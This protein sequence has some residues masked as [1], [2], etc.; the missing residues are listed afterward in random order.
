MPWTRLVL[1]SQSLGECNMAVATARLSLANVV[2]DMDSIQGVL[3]STA[4]LE[5]QRRCLMAQRP[6]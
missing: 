5:E 1:L 4:L 2:A 3:A 6:F